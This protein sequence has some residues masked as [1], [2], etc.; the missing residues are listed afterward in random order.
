MPASGTMVATM[1]TPQRNL[2]S[3]TSTSAGRAPRR[4]RSTSLSIL[5]KPASAAGTARTM[6]GQ[7]I[8]GGDSCGAPGAA[9]ALGGGGRGRGARGGGGGGGRAR[10]RGRAGGA[11]SPPPGAPG[12]ARGGGGG[13]GGPQHAAPLP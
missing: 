4:R 6:S 5:A 3:S 7:V 8:T 13:R 12:G 2:L 1:A 9:G 11:A 10:R